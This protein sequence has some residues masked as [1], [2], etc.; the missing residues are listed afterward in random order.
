[1]IQPTGGLATRLTPEEEE[2]SMA[3]VSLEQESNHRERL[4]SPQEMP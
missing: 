4:A 1:M 2:E 3:R